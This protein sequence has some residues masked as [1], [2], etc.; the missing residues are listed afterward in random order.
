[1]KNKKRK[2]HYYNLQKTLRY[3]LQSTKKIQIQLQDANFSWNSS[4]IVVHDS[5]EFWF[6]TLWEMKREL[7]RVNLEMITSS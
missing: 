4:F 6:I 2:I 5:G 7:L 3:I 1:M